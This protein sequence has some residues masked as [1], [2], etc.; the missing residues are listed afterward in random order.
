MY[1]C[2]LLGSSD[3]PCV[4]RL[5]LLVPLQ[6]HEFPGSPLCQSDCSKKKPK[7]DRPSR[8]YF[9]FTQG[10]GLSHHAPGKLTAAVAHEGIRPFDKHWKDADEVITVTTDLHKALR[11]T[12][13]NNPT[14][15]EI[16]PRMCK[17]TDSDGDSV[18]EPAE[19]TN[20]WPLKGE[21]ARSR[22]GVDEHG[23]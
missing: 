15:S 17:L 5:L 12:D 16:S 10:Q 21:P 4:L 19:S 6:L 23:R 13:S 7:T 3:R 1:G 14:S 9:S 22:G 11:L 2:S 20:S 8:S 18:G